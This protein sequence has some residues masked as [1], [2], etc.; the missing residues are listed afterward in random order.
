V[1]LETNKGK[2]YEVPQGCSNV[3]A[4]DC[5]SKKP[6]WCAG[7]LGFWGGFGASDRVDRLGVVWGK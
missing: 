7:L 4:E 6:D 3:E 2:K 5:E 1:V